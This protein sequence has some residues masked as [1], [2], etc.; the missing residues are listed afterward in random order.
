MTWS[1][2]GFSAPHLRVL[3]RDPGHQPLVAQRVYHDEQDVRRV[4]LCRKNVYRRQHLLCPRFVPG[5]AGSEQHFHAIPFR[6]RRG[7][8]GQGGTRPE[9]LQREVPDGIRI[10][11]APQVVVEN[12]TRDRAPILHA[13]QH[14][15]QQAARTKLVNPAQF[16]EFLADPKQCLPG[17][18]IQCFAI[19]AHRGGVRA[20]ERSARWRHR[21]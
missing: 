19:D 9:V 20:F 4:T 18:A 11:T 13:A 17:G 10:A 12:R 16:A 3:C 7:K 6:H 15:Q 21:R 2:A 5:S 8:H 14:S 1:R